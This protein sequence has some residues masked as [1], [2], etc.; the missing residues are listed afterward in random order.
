MVSRFSQQKRLL[1]SSDYCTEVS[2]TGATTRWVRTN[3]T[4][5]CL[6]SSCA[7]RQAFIDLAAI[8]G[9]APDW[10]CRARR[11]APFTKL[12][13]LWK[14]LSFVMHFTPVSEVI[15]HRRQLP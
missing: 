10:S 7:T 3:F 5:P 12:Y 14:A 1:Q 15:S 13:L 4:C 2:I 8:S 6:I 9:N 11:A